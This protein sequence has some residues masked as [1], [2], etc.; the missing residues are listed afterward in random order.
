MKR[1]YTAQSGHTLFL[2]SMDI[3]EAANAI[4]AVAGDYRNVYAVK[5][6]DAEGV[7]FFYVCTG[8]T[9]EAGKT[10]NEVHVFYGN[11]QMWHSSGKNI[12]E[13]IDGAQRDGWLYTR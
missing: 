5:N 1:T 11:G 7:V 9:D 13:A 2:D 12:Q 3:V 10:Y 4:S 8:Y 6:W